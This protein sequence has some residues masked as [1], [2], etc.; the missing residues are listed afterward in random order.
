MAKI[1]LRLTHAQ[2]D[3][4]RTEIKRLVDDNLVGTGPRYTAPSRIARK[5]YAQRGLKG[6]PQFFGVGCVEYYVSQMLKDGELIAKEDENGE[7]YIVTKENPNRDLTEGPIETK[8][9]NNMEEKEVKKIE[10]VDKNDK[11]ADEKFARMVE[12][13]IQKSYRNT[14]E[15]KTALNRALMG[16][17]D[18]DI[19][20]ATGAPFLKV[21]ERWTIR[22]IFSIETGED[23][24][25]LYKEVYYIENPG[26]YYFEEVNP[27]IYRR[28]AAQH[29]EGDRK[30][31]EAVSKHE[32]IQIVED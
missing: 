14:R 26:K 32:N 4:V 9:E 8:Q 1:K 20:D 24:F 18:E 21:C 19:D 5:V 29:E 28:I 15:F 7:C 17:Y 2:R 30:W 11:K 31:A 6:L 16:G 22:K 27:T 23:Y 13:K 25:K 10:V 12:N 3:A